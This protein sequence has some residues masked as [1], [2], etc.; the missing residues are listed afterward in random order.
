MFVMRRPSLP[1]H[2]RFLRRC[3]PATFAVCL[4]VTM[5]SAACGAEPQRSAVSRYPWTAAQ[6]VDGPTLVR[7]LSARQASDPVRIA[8]TGPPF[9]YRVGHVPGAVMLG[10]ASSPAGLR[11]LETWASPLPRGSKIVV[12]CGCCPLDDCPNLVPA[13]ALLRQ[14]G[15]THVRVL[16]LPTSFGADWA[17]RGFPIER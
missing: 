11:A 16:I 13:F 9:L 15:F 12:Y 17:G 10:P 3:S 5:A 8:F 7:E 6:T 1:S 4:L 2:S 14:M